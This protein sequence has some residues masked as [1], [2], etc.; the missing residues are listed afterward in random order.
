MDLIMPENMDKNEILILGKGPGWEK[1]P[2]IQP[3]WGVNDFLFKRPIDAVFELHDFTWSDERLFQHQK[4]YL[5]EFYD[6]DVLWAK[7]SRKKYRWMLM[8]EVINF[9]GIPLYSL[10]EY[11]WIPSSKRYPLENII[12]KFKT[13]YFHCGISYMIAYAVFIGA[14]KIHLAGINVPG[15]YSYQRGAI[16]H[17]LGIALGS[18]CKV[19]VHGEFSYLLR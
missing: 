19:E 16:E 9:L 2:E 11:D 10:R 15:E 6:D 4:T 13:D 14:K 1:A 12:K 7:V 18:G 17:W 8:A 3:A 5:G